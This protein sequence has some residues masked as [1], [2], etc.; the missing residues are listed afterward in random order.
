MPDKYNIK[1]IDIES[2][3]IHLKTDILNDNLEN[4]IGEQ[5]LIILRTMDKYPQFNGYDKF[6]LNED[7]ISNNE[8]IIKLMTTSSVISDTGPMAS[9]AGS[10]SQVCLEYLCRQ[11]TK[12]SIIENGGDISLKTN[13]ESIISVYAGDNNYYN[14]LAFKINKKRKGYGICTSSGTFGHSKSFGVSDA[15]IVFAEEASIADGLA[16]RFANMANG[17]DNEET[18]NNVLEISDNYREYYDAMIV[19]KDNLIAKNGRIPELISINN[20]SEDEYDME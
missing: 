17:K 4:L 18:V 1:D 12:Y 8:R 3:H 9:V 6:E 5:R 2:T 15:T 16:T 19:I 10:M 13:K 14:S 20:N 7:D 11:N